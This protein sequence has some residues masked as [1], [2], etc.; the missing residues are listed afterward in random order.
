MNINNDER[1]VLTL[2]AGGT[3]FVF[4]AIKNGKAITHEVKKDANG[5]DL[6]KCI[7]TLKAGFHAQNTSKL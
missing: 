7:A 6:N 3:N 1:V 5:H 4:T 2:D